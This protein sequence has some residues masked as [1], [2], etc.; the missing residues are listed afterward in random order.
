V[1]KLGPRGAVNLVKVVPFVG[2]LLSG[3][4]DATATKVI[5][6]TAKQ[7]FVPLP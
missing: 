2:G 5:G 3:A 7:V 1:T 6:A 4:L